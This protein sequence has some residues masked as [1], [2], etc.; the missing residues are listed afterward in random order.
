M[1]VNVKHIFRLING[2]TH[3]YHESGDFPSQIRALKLVSM[4]CSSLFIDD[5]F[6]LTPCNGHS[7]VWKT[8]LVSILA[9]YFGLNIRNK[10][11]FLNVCPYQKLKLLFYSRQIIICY[12]LTEQWTSLILHR[13]CSKVTVPKE[14]FT[15]EIKY[16][17]S[18]KFTFHYS[19]FWIS[20][21]K[22]YVD[23]IRN[24]YHKYCLLPFSSSKILKKGM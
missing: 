21:N 17:V 11:F 16:I 6:N 5:N 20:Q 12:G 9:K 18:N 15:Q 1:L 14:T 8:S 4:H 13:I 10:C 22:C 19:R 24:I 7:Y 3:S 23:I 2:I